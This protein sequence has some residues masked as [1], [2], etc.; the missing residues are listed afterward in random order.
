MKKMT[1]FSMH[2]GKKDHIGENGGEWASTL[3][4]YHGFTR[5]EPPNGKLC[6]RCKAAAEFRIEENKQES[7]L[8][9]ELMS[10]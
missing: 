5:T 2:A 10:K 3:C 6:K 7:K 8:L 4:G 9:K 1:R